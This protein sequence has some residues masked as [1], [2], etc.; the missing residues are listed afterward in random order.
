MFL[1]NVLFPNNPFIS[2]VISLALGY[3]MCVAILFLQE[4]AK[5]MSKQMENENEMKQIL[6]EDIYMLVAG[7]AV[8]TSWRGLWMVFDAM[9]YQFPIYYRGRDVTPLVGCL[10]S[11]LLLAMA[12]VTNS[13]PYK[14]C[15]RDGEIKGGEGLCCST[16]YFMHFF[17]EWR[18]YDEEDNES[19]MDVMEVKPT[20]NGASVVTSLENDSAAR[21]RIVTK[22]APSMNG[23]ANGNVVS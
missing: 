17:Q 14:G 16:D 11:Y 8:I 5:E 6:F 20:L 7:F 12:H 21:R 10:T 9:S 15:E 2:M 18:E 19:D 23:L 1:D 13:L 4:R 3:A 22:E